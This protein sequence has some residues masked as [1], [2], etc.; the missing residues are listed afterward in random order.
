M[1]ATRKGELYRTIDV[2]ENILKEQGL[3][4]VLAFIY[5]AQYTRKD[6]KDTLELLKGQKYDWSK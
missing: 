3:Y 2:L 4:F 6:I 1:G 5:D